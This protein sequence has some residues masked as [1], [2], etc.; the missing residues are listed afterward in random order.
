MGNTF[1]SHVASG[2]IV[3]KFNDMLTK[4]WLVTTSQAPSAPVELFTDNP[5]SGANIFA[6]PCC[7]KDGSSSKPVMLDGDDVSEAL[8]D[9]TNSQMTKRQPPK[10]QKRV[11]SPAEM[12]GAMTGK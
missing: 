3:F 5:V 8:L 4:H 7:F 12:E 10:R 2:R 6:T 9:L 1:Y 11:F